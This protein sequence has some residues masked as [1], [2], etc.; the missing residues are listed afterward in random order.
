MIII[1]FFVLLQKFV[2]YFFRN[3]D[4]TFKVKMKMIMGFLKVVLKLYPM[5][6]KPPN[7]KGV[8]LGPMGVHRGPMTTSGIYM[9]VWDPWV[10]L[11]TVAI[12]NAIVAKGN[13]LQFSH[14]IRA[15]P[16][17]LLSYGGNCKCYYCQRKSTAI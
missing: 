9:I 15:C 2:F 7:S 16:I 10:P 12:A 5:V 8:L 17:I 4:N 3:T 1:I 13:W 6:T 14:I 11:L